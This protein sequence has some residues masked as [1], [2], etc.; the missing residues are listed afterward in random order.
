MRSPKDVMSVLAMKVAC[1]AV[2]VGQAEA[3]TVSQ[4]ALHRGSLIVAGYQAAPSAVI[5]WQG[6][7]VTLATGRGGFAFT[8]AAVPAGCIGTLS[9]GVTTVGVAVGGCT[10]EP[11]W[12]E[13]PL[14]VTGQATCM[15][16]GGATIDCAGTG[17]DGEFRTG[18]VQR[19]TSHPNGTI[20]DNNTGL[21][22][23]KKTAAN[24]LDAYTF[25]E[26]F[27]YVAGLN[28]RRFAGHDD[29]RVPNLR[30]L[31]SLIDYGRFDPAVAP[32]FNDCDNGSCTASG[33]Y[34]SSTSAVS[35]GIL[36]WRVNF[37]DGF[38]ITGGKTFTIRVRAVRGGS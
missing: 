33:S 2:L 10:I 6:E 34:W 30:E 22:W 8:T 20:T 35:A 32:E 16:V 25:D 24:V 11:D 15:N 29:W 4:A 18:V 17:Q 14:L 36:A 19:Y 7:A 9:D 21:V 28:E 31:Q 12:L 23:E 37:V 26:A 38:Q 27:V 1:L 5:V 13:A 3:L